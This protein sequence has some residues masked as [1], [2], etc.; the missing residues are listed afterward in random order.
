MPPDF[1]TPERKK[2]KEFLGNIDP[3]K[4]TEKLRSK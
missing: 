4:N 1:L 2:K 3:E